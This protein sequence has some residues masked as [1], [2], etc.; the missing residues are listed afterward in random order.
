MDGESSQLMAEFRVEETPHFMLPVKIFPLF[1]LMQNH[2]VEP[3]I[4]APPCCMPCRTKHEVLDIP[5]LQPHTPKLLLVFCSTQ[6]TGLF[7]DLCAIIL[8]YG[9]EQGVQDVSGASSHHITAV[10]CLLSLFYL[11]WVDLGWLSCAHQAALSLPLHQQD[12]GENY[13]CG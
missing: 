3:Y 8:L 2:Y 5:A 6:G 9:M 11:C 12:G 7:S 13:W 1:Y 4:A 10:L